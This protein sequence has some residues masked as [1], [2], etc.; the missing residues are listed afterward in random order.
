MLLL[1][2]SK[3]ASSTIS[4]CQPQSIFL[5]ILISLLEFVCFVKT[6]LSP[7]S[8]INT[9]SVLNV[10]C[11][12]CIGKRTSSSNDGRGVHQSVLLV[13]FATFTGDGPYSFF[14]SISHCTQFDLN[15]VVLSIVLVASRFGNSHW[16][17][18]KKSKQTGSTIKR[19]T[20][21]TKMLHQI[22]Y[23]TWKNVMLKSDKVKEFDM[24]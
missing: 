11:A 2:L 14:H 8:Y 4:F 7:I 13:T 16:Q 12:M 1:A 21:Y 23:I 15:V 22:T 9:I 24:F 3:Y 19:H 20:L 17:Q 6:T 18:T 5:S 10:H